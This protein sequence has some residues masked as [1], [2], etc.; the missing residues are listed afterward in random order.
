MNILP[1]SNFDYYEYTF[2]SL[3]ANQG[4]VSGVAITDW[5]MFKI[6][7]PLQNVVGIKLIETEI[8]FSY[9]IVST[10]NNKFSVSYSGGGYTVLTIPVGNYSSTTLR[11]AIETALQTVNASFTVAIDTITSKFVFT[12]AAVFIFSF[13]TA[14]DVDLRVLLG[15]MSGFKTALLTGGLYVLTSENVFS[16]TGPNYLYLNSS[17][18]GPLINLYLPE[19]DLTSRGGIGPHMCK[20]QVTSNPFDVITWRDPSSDFFFD[21]NNIFELSSMDFYLT[22][23]VGVNQKPLRLN[24]LGF[25]L[26]IGVL[27]LKDQKTV[28][29]DN[30][31][32]IRRK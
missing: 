25:S 9:Y 6:A 15:F 5:P 22:A 18:L 2:D 31:K 19:N 28:S 23:G 8:P 30:V 4:A 27:V 24:G 20:I 11:T 14:L 16:I 1:D 7:N 32:K 12:A 10:E 29:D 3:N 26:K 21:L 17:K 13:N